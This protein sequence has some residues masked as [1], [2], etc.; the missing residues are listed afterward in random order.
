MNSKIVKGVFFMSDCL[1]CKIIDGS[2]PST[3][4][5]EDEYVYAFMDISPLTKGHTLLIP[6]EHV[7]NVFEMSEETAANLF[8]VAPRIANAIKDSFKPAGMNLLNNNGAPAGQSV[9]H[10]HL[11]FIP[12]YDET[13]G[14]KPTWI[15][16]QDE[17]TSDILQGLA[18]EIKANLNK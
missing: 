15:T 16:K 3:K 12:R 4:I 5:Y 8:K 13:D 17:F 14:Y 6:K 9:F 2:I 11:H 7:A 18:E 10:F 1:F